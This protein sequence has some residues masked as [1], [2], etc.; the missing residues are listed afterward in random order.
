VTGAWRHGDVRHIVA[1]PAAARATLG[2]TA[3]VSFEDGIAELA[4]DE[5]ETA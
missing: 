3:E 2:F 4:R 1:S 5:Q